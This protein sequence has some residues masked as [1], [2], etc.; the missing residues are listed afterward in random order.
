MHCIVHHMLHFRIHSAHLN[1]GQLCSGLISEQGTQRIRSVAVVTQERPHRQ[2]TISTD[3]FQE[4]ALCPYRKL[5]LRIGQ[6][7]ELVQKLPV[8]RLHLQRQYPLCRCRNY[9]FRL[10]VLRNPGLKPK[11][12]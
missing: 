5:R 3:L 11:S 9:L 7:I 12:L 2:M 4:T 1:P 8:I 6:P 10:Q